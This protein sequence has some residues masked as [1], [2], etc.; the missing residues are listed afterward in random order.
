MVREGYEE[1]PDLGLGIKPFVGLLTEEERQED[2]TFGLGRGITKGSQVSC[3][4]NI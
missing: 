1:S 4:R 2:D 3:Y